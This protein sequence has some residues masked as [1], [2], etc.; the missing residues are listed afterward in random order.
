[1]F[2]DALWVYALA[3]ALTLGCMLLSGT[4]HPPAGANALIM[5]H[6][7][8]DVSALWMPVLIGVS[9]LALVA[10]VWSRLGARWFKEQTRYPARWMDRSPPNLLWGITN[11][12]ED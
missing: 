11:E 2:G 8:A 3:Q 1:M 4:V 9:T 10:V 7:H 12:N 6:A 5:I